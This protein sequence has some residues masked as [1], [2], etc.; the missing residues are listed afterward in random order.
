MLRETLWCVFQVLSFGLDPLF[1]VCQKAKIWSPCMVEQLLS[2]ESNLRILFNSF[3]PLA[4]QNKVIPILSHFILQA[5]LVLLFCRLPFLKFPRTPSV[6]DKVVSTLD[7]HHPL[8]PCPPGQYSMCLEFHWTSILFFRFRII[9]HSLGLKCWHFS[10]MTFFRSSFSYLASK[11]L[12]MIRIELI[13]LS[14]LR[15]LSIYKLI[16]Y[17]SVL[18]IFSIKD[19]KS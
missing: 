15:Y 16:N 3:L 10:V 7:S 14:D 4:G 2:S 1:S 18:T 5:P 17:S 13:E 8:I 11:M 19:L 9:Y 12:R 6:L